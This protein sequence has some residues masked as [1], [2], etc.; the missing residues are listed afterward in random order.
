MNSNPDANR[1]TPASWQSNVRERVIVFLAFLTSEE[2]RAACR[3]HARPEEL[4]AA[5]TSLWFD[6]IYVPAETTVTGLQP[7]PGEEELAQFR[8]CF[9]ASELETLERFHGFFELRLE[10]VSN[11]LYG[12]AFFPE[13]DSWR[14]ILQHASYVLTELAP[15]P[16]QL[17]AVLAQLVE[18]TKRG[19]LMEALRAPRALTSPE[20]P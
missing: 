3:E 8:S 11:R 16:E 1:D 19:R 14:S 10:F 17:R 7:T 13:N 20:R 4:A 9:S 18:R 15:D 12:R 2:C 5:L 6:E